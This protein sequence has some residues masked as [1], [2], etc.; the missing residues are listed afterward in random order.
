ME[1]WN[2]WSPDPSWMF[3]GGVVLLCAVLLRR[4]LLKTCKR[5]RGSGELVGPGIS[6][7]RLDRL[8]DA[9]PEAVRWH[10]E[11]HEIARDAKAELDSKMRALTVLLRDAAEQE[12]RLRRL[13]AECQQRDSEATE[14]PRPR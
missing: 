11:M 10:V 12:E 7:S 9:P 6:F 14:E 5:G 2:D 4:Y 3:L 1:L 13:L 8:G